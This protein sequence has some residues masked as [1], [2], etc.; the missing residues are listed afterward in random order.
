MAIYTFKCRTC[1]KESE[2][3]MAMSEFKNTIKN[4]KTTKCLYCGK[5]ADL[6]PSF[7]SVVYKGTGWYVTD[8]K[9]KPRKKDNA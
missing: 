9:D 7:A 4:T 3:S 8:Y 5:K 2:L 6:L 1:D